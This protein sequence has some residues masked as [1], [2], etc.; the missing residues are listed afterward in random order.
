MFNGDIGKRV[1]DMN[2]IITNIRTVPIHF[3]F[4]IGIKISL[5][6]KA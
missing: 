1:E 2:K 5:S 4:L 6:N 3:K